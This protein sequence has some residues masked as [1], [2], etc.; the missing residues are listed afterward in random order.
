MFF[1]ITNNYDFIYGLPH[2][3]IPFWLMRVMIDSYGGYLVPCG[4]VHR[5]I[6]FWGITL[7]LISLV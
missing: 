1:T 6:S 4:G 7:L 2:N 5:I 3:V